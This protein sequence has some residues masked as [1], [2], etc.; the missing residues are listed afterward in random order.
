MNRQAVVNAQGFQASSLALRVPLI[1]TAPRASETVSLWSRIAATLDTWNAR[2][3]GRRELAQ[4]DERILQDIGMTRS[5]V[6]MELD[7]PFWRP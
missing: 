2:R 3:R 5:Q 7:K 6:A 4:L 1:S